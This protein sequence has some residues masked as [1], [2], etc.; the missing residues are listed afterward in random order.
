MYLRDNKDFGS[1]QPKDLLKKRSHKE[2]TLH[3]QQ[4]FSDET[5]LYNNSD[6]K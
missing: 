4:T 2:K 5:L 6:F 3:K 1:F